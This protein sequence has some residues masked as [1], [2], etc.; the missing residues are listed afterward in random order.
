MRFGF[1]L[2]NWTLL[3]E[4][5]KKQASENETA[6]I[7]ESPFGIRYIVDGRIETP[8]KRNPYV[9]TVWII[10]KEDIQPRLVTV[11]PV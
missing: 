5:L 8:D 3:A 9:R 4:A 11:H 2:E 7:V 10:E 1:S 6:S